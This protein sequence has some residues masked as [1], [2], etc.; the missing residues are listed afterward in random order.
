LDDHHVQITPP[1]FHL[2][3]LPFADDFRKLTF[4]EGERGKNLIFI[5]IP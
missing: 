1:G 4:E 5:E 3:V 2:L